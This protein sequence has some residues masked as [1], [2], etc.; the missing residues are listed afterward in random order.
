MD[1]TDLCRLDADTV[2]RAV[3]LLILLRGIVAHFRSVLDSGR[4]TRCVYP[5]HKAKLSKSSTVS[6][7]PVH[8]TERRSR[9]RATS[10]GRMWCSSS[11]HILSG[12]TWRFI[13]VTSTVYRWGSR[14][15]PAGTIFQ[16][17]TAPSPPKRENHLIV[18]TLL[19]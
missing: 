19:E 13:G 15:G 16:W 5:D 4:V 17:N 9:T 2:G 18:C 8:A 10:R 11:Y 12:G 3:R 1:Y 14:Y 7:I 6:Y